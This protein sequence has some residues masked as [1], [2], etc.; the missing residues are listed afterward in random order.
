MS[1][2][3]HGV[4]HRPLGETRVTE[5]NKKQKAPQRDAKRAQRDTNDLKEIQNQHKETHSCDILSFC[6]ILHHLQSG[7]L[8]LT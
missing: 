2:L 5:R 3:A 1:Q 8:T 4:I 7:C 6:V